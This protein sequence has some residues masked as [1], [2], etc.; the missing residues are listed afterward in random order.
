MN[1]FHGNFGLLVNS[2]SFLM[3]YDKLANGWTGPA[4]PSTE[5][6][7]A[8]PEVDAVYCATMRVSDE[9]PVEKYQDK[10]K[11]AEKK[12]EKAK[13]QED[14]RKERLEE[15]RKAREERE[16]EKEVE[17]RAIDAAYLVEAQRY[18]E[19]DGEIVIVREWD[20]EFKDY[21]E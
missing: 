3:C 16:K 21:L 18:A 6:E 12:R 17:W 19:E 9:E 10:T 11:K 14:A 7:L 4:L 2:S 20:E 5:A 1:M 8:S 13:E 15:K